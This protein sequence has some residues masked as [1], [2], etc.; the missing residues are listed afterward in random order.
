[1]LLDKS[2]FSSCKFTYHSLHWMHGTHTHTHTLMLST[3]THRRTPPVALSQHVI[4]MMRCVYASLQTHTTVL[5]LNYWWALGFLHLSRSTRSDV[6]AQSTIP[7]HKHTK[8]TLF[9]DKSFRASAD[10]IYTLTNN[11]WWEINLPWQSIEQKWDHKKLP[12]GKLIW[13]FLHMVYS[14]EKRDATFLSPNLFLFAWLIFQPVFPNFLPTGNQDSCYYQSGS[15]P[16]PECCKS[17]TTWDKVPS[18]V[19]E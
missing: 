10:W 1:M 14:W 13:F 7:P 12:A 8:Y 3:W 16:H 11:Q 19:R 4:L 18:E 2:S 6:K 9:A 17:I 5:L 15:S